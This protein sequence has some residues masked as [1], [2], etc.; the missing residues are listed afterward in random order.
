MI[1]EPKELLEHLQSLADTHGEDVLRCF[2]DDM[3]DRS[4]PVLEDIRK[5]LGSAVAGVKILVAVL[6]PRGG[7]IHLED[8]KQACLNSD[9]LGLLS[10]AIFLFTSTKVMLPAIDLL[11][12]LKAKLEESRV[13]S[14]HEA[15]Y[16]N[17][18]I[19]HC[20]EIGQFMVS[21]EQQELYLSNAV[22]GYRQVVS[23]RVFSELPE[24][25][26]ANIYDCLAY[27]GLSS[28][29]MERQE[30]WTHESK[31]LEILSTGEALRSF[32]H[33]RHALSP[34]RISELLL[35]ADVV[36]EVDNAG[37]KS[38]SLL[39]IAL[40]HPYFVGHL[41]REQQRYVGTKLL[42]LIRS[43]DGDVA[44]G[45][46]EYD[47]FVD[48]IPHIEVQKVLKWDLEPVRSDDVRP[49]QARMPSP[50]MP[51]SKENEQGRLSPIEEAGFKPS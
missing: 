17:Y 26:Q 46:S 40:G 42:N 41:S 21:A 49:E 29:L 44:F 19:A 16:L 28:G 27:S 3:F 31:V 7:E 25:M 6:G 43:G 33:T 14:D 8:V 5:E 18:Q 22:N 35:D 20:Y 10:L 45:S 34:V 4:S 39:K 38:F 37:E 32:F 11:T 47:D 51:A 2:V 1:I 12:H 30:A 36:K 50:V 15:L 23:S 9:N 48:Q 13:L 24:T